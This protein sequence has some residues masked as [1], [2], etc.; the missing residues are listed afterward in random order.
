MGDPLCERRFKRFTGGE[1]V[2]VVA[3]VWAP[4]LC[5]A[6]SIPGEYDCRVEVEGLPDP[7]EVDVHGVD[8]MQALW[9]ALNFVHRLLRPFQEQLTWL[10]DE[11]DGEIGMPLMVFGF[12]FEM[13][14]RLE[15]VVERE[16]TAIVD[17]KVAKRRAQ[18]KL[19]DA[20]DA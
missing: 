12:D 19:S 16:H 3:R 14:R 7:I 11:A 10:G 20:E 6:H 15:E 1:T 13:Q 2:E 18:R 5:E 4:Q 8:A 9:V 17:E